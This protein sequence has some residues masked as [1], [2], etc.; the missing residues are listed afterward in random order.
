LNGFLLDFHL[1]SRDSSMA[2][3]ITA[4]KNYWA[5]ACCVLAAILAGVVGYFVG[6]GQ[7][8]PRAPVNAFPG[9][10]Q[11]ALENA[12]E[13]A[14]AKARRAVAEKEAAAAKSSKAN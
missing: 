1:F 11:S 5:L 14:R 13:Q 6:F 4:S 8:D 3:Q 9:V 12:V 10:S 7:S 2:S